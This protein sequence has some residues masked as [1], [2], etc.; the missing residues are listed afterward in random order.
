VARVGFRICG[1]P[2]ILF[3]FSPALLGQLLRNVRLVLGW[4]FLHE[5]P[6]R[7]GTLVPGDNALRTRGNLRCRICFGSGQLA[8]RNLAVRIPRLGASILLGQ[9]FGV[10]LQSGF[11]NAVDF[12]P[13]TIDLIFS[14]VFMAVDR[15]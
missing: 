4:G 6:G 2:E 12:F 5:M 9:V 10:L 11:S 15:F 8:K 3:G 14:D 7:F 13:V 1:P